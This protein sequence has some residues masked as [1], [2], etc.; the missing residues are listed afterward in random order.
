MNQSRLALRKI[1]QQFALRK[2]KIMLFIT[3]Y[4]YKVCF[5]KRSKQDARCTTAVTETSHSSDVTT[6]EAP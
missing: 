3:E 1:E 5:I 2:K 6:V 4:Y